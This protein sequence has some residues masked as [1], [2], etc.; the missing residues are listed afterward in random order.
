[1]NNND[2]LDIDVLEDYLDG[3]LDAKTMHRVERIS[4]D[5]PFVAEALAGLSQSPRRAQSLSLLQ[6]QLQE[7]IAQKSVEQK[8]WQITSHR[9]SIAAAA[10]VLFVTVSMLFWM[11]ES[12]N[13]ELLTTNAPKKVDVS[14]AQNSTISKP[15][16]AA[17]AAMERVIADSKTTTYATQKIKVAHKNIRANIAQAP[18]SVNSNAKQNPDV[19]LKTAENAPQELKEVVITGRAEEK[20]T[21]AFSSAEIVTRPTPTPVDGMEFYQNYLKANNKLIKEGLKGN[22]VTLSFLIAKDGSPLDIK[23]L[24]GIS[25]A[26]NKEAIRLVKKG[27][28]WN[29]LANGNNTVN[30]KVQF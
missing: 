20:R 4:L 28:K 3:K 1:V 9:L 13:R 15:S 19:K 2:W 11:R 24:N 10:A 23:V 6:K 12:R 18:E 17:Q 16:P 29:F 26:Y 21:R 22:D 25:E 8:R 7:R 14:I 30:L 5:D 27:P